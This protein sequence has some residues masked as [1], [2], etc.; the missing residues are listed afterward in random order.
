[1][2]AVFRHLFRNLA[3]PRPAVSGEEAD[4][5]REL[6]SRSKSRVPATGI[7]PVP[8]DSKSIMLPLHQADTWWNSAFSHEANKMF[9]K[10]MWK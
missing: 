10:E 8:I 4:I 7:E 3:I 1:M 9:P 2:R 5:R 6:G